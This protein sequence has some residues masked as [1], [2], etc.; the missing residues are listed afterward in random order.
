M[1]LGQCEGSGFAPHRLLADLSPWPHPERALWS[2]TER[3]GTEPL[4][5]SHTQ[6]QRTHLALVIAVRPG[7]LWTTWERKE[8]K[9]GGATQWDPVQKVNTPPPTPPEQQQNHSS[10]AGDG[11]DALKRQ[12]MQSRET[13]V[14][15]CY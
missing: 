10:Q 9:K 2:W 15:C 11:E 4:Q 8:E 14:F 3:S 6:T 1:L 13:E 12:E 5:V 7:E